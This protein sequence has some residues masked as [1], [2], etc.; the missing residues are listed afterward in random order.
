MQSVSSHGSGETKSSFGF[1]G[2]LRP[3]FQQ[4][5]AFRPNIYAPSVYDVFT[6]EKGEYIDTGE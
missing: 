1:T 4:P 6:S 5:D 2:H 3:I